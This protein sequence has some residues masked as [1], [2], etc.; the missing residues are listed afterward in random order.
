MNCGLLKRPPQQMV[1]T[2]R[3]NLRTSC[4]LKEIEV[5][6]YFVR[7]SSYLNLNSEAQTRGRFQDCIAHG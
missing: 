4:A 3:T 1:E 6:A 2:Q 5:L 7:A